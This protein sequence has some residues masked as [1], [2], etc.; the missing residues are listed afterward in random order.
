MLQLDLVLRVRE[1][2]IKACRRSGPRHLHLQFLPAYAYL[3][4]DGPIC[5]FDRLYKKVE[6]GVEACCAYV[7]LISC[8]NRRID[9]RAYATEI[10]YQTES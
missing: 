1:R 4:A 10:K 2:I 3:R 7:L 6:P 8:E 9:P 5:R